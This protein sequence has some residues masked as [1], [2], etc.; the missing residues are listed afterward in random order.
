MLVLSVKL[1][2]ILIFDRI[3]PEYVFF[4]VL[5]SY[6]L[7]LN[8]FQYLYCAVLIAYKLSLNFFHRCNHTYASLSVADGVGFYHESCLH[9]YL[10]C[11][12]FSLYG[13]AGF[14]YPEVDN[15]WRFRDSIAYACWSWGTAFFLLIVLACAVLIAMVFHC[16]FLRISSQ[17]LWSMPPAHL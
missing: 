3:K 4:I 11:C 6:K 12:C 5:V 14:Q 9:W 13:V 7:S 1:M 8:F 10:D 15:C 2:L 17:V 16:R